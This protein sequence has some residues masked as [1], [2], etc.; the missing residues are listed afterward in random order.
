M[1]FFAGSGW[2]GLLV[3]R[4]ASFFGTLSGSNFGDLLEKPP[5]GVIV[6]PNERVRERMRE[7]ERG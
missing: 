1:I 2:F 3:C 6:Q 7:G 5:M 4:V